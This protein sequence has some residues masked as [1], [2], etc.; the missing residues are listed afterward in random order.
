[1]SGRSPGDEYLDRIIAE[2]SGHTNCARCGGTHEELAW[3]RF[4]LQPGPPSDGGFYRA[5]A[6]CPTTGDPI[7]FEIQEVQEPSPDPGCAASAIQVTD[8]S[9]AASMQAGW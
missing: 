9:A 4:E 8:G 1:M 3:K 5:W 2:R 6:L 7:M